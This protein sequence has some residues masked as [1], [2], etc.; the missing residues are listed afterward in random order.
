MASILAISSQVARGYVGLNALV[1][2]LQACG[3]DVVALPTVLL[4]NHPGHGATAGE[5]I[6]PALLERMLDALEDHAW[7]GEVAAVVSGYLPSPAHVAFVVEAVARV[8]SANPAAQFFC[9]PV[10]GDDPKGLYVDA[11]AALGIRDRLMPI[12]DVALP[13]RFELAWLTGRDVSDV[14]SA[15]AACRASGPALVV[16]T[17]IP[18]GPARLATVAAGADQ[19]WTAQVERR[20]GVPNGTGDLLSGLLIGAAVAGASAPEALGMA[21]ATVARVV[22]DSVGR[23]ELSIGALHAGLV[24]DVPSVKAQVFPPRPIRR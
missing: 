7:L 4:S 19:A 20:S 8:R 10:L 16:A 12:A 1:P 21:V 5:R 6:A 3:H 15:V 13:N 24:H 9:D 17:S 11:A 2:A 18:D 22:D 23:S 14:A